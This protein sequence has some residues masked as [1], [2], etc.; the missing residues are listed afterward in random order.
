MLPRSSMAV[1]GD[2]LGI[3]TIA[4]LAAVFVLATEAVFLFARRSRPDA[5][6]GR[7]RVFWAVTPALILAGLC[8]WCQAYVLDHAAAAPVDAIAQR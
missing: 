5:H 7:S 8:V 2:A 6:S 3:W 4:R 1:A